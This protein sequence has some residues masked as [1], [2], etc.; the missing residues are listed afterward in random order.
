MEMTTMTTGTAWP[1]NPVSPRLVSRSCAAAVNPASMTESAFVRSCSAPRAAAIASAS[2]LLSRKLKATV[3]LTSYTMAATRTPSSDTRAAML[4]TM[5]AA[6]WRTSLPWSQPAV[7]RETPASMT[8]TTSAWCAWHG[9]VVGVVVAL[10]VWVVV[11]HR[12]LSAAMVAATARHVGASCDSA[13]AAT[14]LA[15][16]DARRDRTSALALGEV[17]TAQRVTLSSAKAP[18]VTSGRSCVVLMPDG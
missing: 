16:V 10:V 12:V 6:N 7:M 2:K 15:G 17:D 13:V 3:P 5:S 14:T 9:V 1:R 4:R 11:S 8:K 18:S